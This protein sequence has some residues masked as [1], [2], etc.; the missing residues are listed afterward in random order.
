MSLFLSH[1]GEFR[2]AV[3]MCS[4]RKMVITGAAV[5]AAGAAWHME[6]VAQENAASGVGVVTVF[7]HVKLDASGD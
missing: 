7:D 4:I 6:S 2:K 3:A 1:F 5:I